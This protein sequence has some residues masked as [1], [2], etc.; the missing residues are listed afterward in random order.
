MRSGTETVEDLEWL[1]G[2][3]GLPLNAIE[4]FCDRWQV[5]ELV[6]TEAD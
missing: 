1:T 5:A 4:A 3:T 6:P 2:R